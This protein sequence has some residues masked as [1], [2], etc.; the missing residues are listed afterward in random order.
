M[1]ERVLR[2]F[3]LVFHNSRLK[4]LTGRHSNICSRTLRMHSVSVCYKQ[5][6]TDKKVAERQQASQTTEIFLYQRLDVNAVNNLTP[7]TDFR[8]CIEQTHFFQRQPHRAPLGQSRPYKQ[9]IDRPRSLH[10]HRHCTRTD[11]AAALTA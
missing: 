11:T 7:S 8:S 6:T 1:Q 9:T 10:T 4:R 3:S 2:L 5:C